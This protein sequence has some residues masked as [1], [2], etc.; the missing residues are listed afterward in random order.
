MKRKP[1]YQMELPKLKDFLEGLQK[2]QNTAKKSIEIAKEAMK[3]QFN[4]KRKNSQELK[5]RDNMCL[6]AKNIQLNRPS[7]KLNQKRYGLF[8]ISKNIGQ[9]TFQLEL[10]KEQTICV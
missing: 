8:R 7:K 2:S 10:L 5:T 3:K 6:E 1:D 9:E 4:R